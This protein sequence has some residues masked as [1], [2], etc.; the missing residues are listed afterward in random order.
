MTSISL[1]WGMPYVEGGLGL[2]SGGLVSIGIRLAA[3][4]A[5]GMI[6]HYRL[7]AVFVSPQITDGQDVYCDLSFPNEYGPLSD[8]KTPASDCFVQSCSLAF[9]ESWGLKSATP[10][11][12]KIQIEAT[13]RMATAILSYV[14]GR[15]YYWDLQYPTTDHTYSMTFTVTT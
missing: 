7:P 1:I 9:D 14:I 10:S 13:V 6:S 3:G 2:E 5:V 8:P 12:F 11:A 4:T 15:G